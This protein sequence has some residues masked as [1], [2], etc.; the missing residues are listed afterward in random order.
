MLYKST[1]LSDDEVNVF[2][3]TNSIGGV[4][5]VYIVKFLVIYNP[6]AHRQE[7]HV[8]YTSEKILAS[9][10]HFRKGVVQ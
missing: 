8:L 1:F 3:Q 5:S 9:G 7:Y 10:M 4:T 2:F 6:E